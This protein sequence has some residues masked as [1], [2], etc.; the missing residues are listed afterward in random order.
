MHSA[1]WEIDASGTFVGSSYI[2]A[3]MRDY[4]RFGLLYLNNGNWMGEQILPEN[5]VEYTCS[6]AN[7]SK[8]QYGAYFWLNKSGKDYPDVPR[9]MYCCRGHDGQYIYIIPSKELVVVRTGFSKKG[10]FDY[11]GFLAGIV[12]AVE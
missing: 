7:G 4:A 1:I 10:M 8:G 3:T 6:E 11:N 5:W 12:N 9:D 2:Y